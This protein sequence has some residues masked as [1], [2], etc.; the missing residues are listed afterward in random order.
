MRRLAAN[1]LDSLSRAEKGRPVDCSAPILAADMRDACGKED[2]V[3][4]LEDVVV[5]VFLFGELF[6]KRKLVVDLDGDGGSSFLCVQ[7]A[8]G[9]VIS[10]CCCE[11]NNSPIHCS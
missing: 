9:G 1:C 2:L 7:K 3:V 4:D 5:A 6:G 8:L 10:R 11:I